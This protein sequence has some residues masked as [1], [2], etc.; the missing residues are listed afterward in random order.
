MKMVAWLLSMLLS[1]ISLA[2]GGSNGAS[3]QTGGNPTGTNNNAPHACT[4]TVVGDATSGIGSL[5]VNQCSSV[6]TDVSAMLELSTVASSNVGFLAA[7]IAGTQEI[8]STMFLIYSN[9]TGE[10]AP[11]TL[12]VNVDITNALPGASLAVG[13]AV[14]AGTSS[15]GAWA[16]SAKAG[17]VALRLT[18]ATPTDIARCAVGAGSGSCFVIRGTLHAVLVPDA[19]TGHPGRGTL[20]MDVTF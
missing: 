5:T 11:K 19:R 18:S 8:E 6:S 13:F 9:L 7:A 4:V 10:T 2:C 20:T 16:A 1:A 17:S 14:V 15:V 12:P 3:T